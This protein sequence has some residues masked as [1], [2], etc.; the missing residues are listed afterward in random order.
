MSS[1]TKETAIKTEQPAA[2]NT[3]LEMMGFQLPLYSTAAKLVFLACG[4]IGSFMVQ[5]FLQEYIFRIPG[6]SFG[7]F[8]ALFEFAVCTIGAA[9][10]P[11]LPTGATLAEQRSTNSTQNGQPH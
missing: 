4:L 11:S 10:V 5:N 8:S 6:F 2:Q 3:P 7:S 1:S 9:G